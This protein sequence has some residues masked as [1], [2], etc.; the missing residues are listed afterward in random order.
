MLSAAIWHNQGLILSA[1][2]QRGMYYYFFYFL[3]LY[4]KPHPKN[5]Q[6]L[7]IAFGLVFMIIYLIQYFI[8]P[9]EILDVLIMRDRGTVRIYM[10]GITF[11]IIGTFLCLQ[12]F[13][14]ENKLKFL[15]YC[16]LSVIILI[17]SGGR[18]ILLLVIFVISLNI[19]L[20]KKIKSKLLVYLIST[21]AIFSI[22]YFFRNIFINFIEI[23][24]LER[25]IGAQNIRL[26]ATVFFISKVFPNTF[27]YIFGNGMPNVRSEYG[28]SFELFSKYFGY[29]ISDIGILGNYVYF[30]LL[31]VIG[32]ILLLRKA[33]TTKVIDNLKYLRYVFILFALCLLTGGGFMNS[34]FIVPLC[35]CLYLID[36]SKANIKSELFSLTN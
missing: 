3:L 36:T 14:N 10:P 26:R 27:A 29:Y 17:L 33:I 8:Y 28:Q 15:I 18:Q 9:L 11:M 22:V 12:Y 6:K 5:I 16:I 20:S 25:R 34:E 31:F 4:I 1:Y 13:L 32:V 7:F 19:L 24:Q 35:L 23:T 30:G 2:E 21:L